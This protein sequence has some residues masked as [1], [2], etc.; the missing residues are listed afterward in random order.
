MFNFVPIDRN[1]HTHIIFKI[2]ILFCYIMNINHKLIEKF[3]L[4]NKL[5]SNIQITYRIMILK[6]EKIQ[7]E[8]GFNNESRK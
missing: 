2:Y 3:N 8:A 1:M 5:Y 6:I 4:L 7:L